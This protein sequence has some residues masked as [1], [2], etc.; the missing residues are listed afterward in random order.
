MEMREAVERY[1]DLVEHAT[2]E[3]ADEFI[4]QIRVALAELLA[5]APG[6]GMRQYDVDPDFGNAMP[7]EAE[8]EMSAKLGPVIGE[9]NFYLMVF[10]PFHDKRLVGALLTEDLASVWRDLKPG[11]DL[12]GGPH[13]DD[14]LFD[15]W[16]GYR[17]P[18]GPHA[19]SAL[20]VLVMS[21][22]F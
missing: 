19:A 4:D 17:G 2:P 18:W 8:S 5:A 11:L 3:T 6:L 7:I 9:R 13:E 16:D 15:W 12:I 20:Y 10:E 1:C 22:Y 14:A 21:A